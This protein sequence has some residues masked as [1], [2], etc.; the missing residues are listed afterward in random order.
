MSKRKGAW[1]FSAVT[2]AV[3]TFPGDMDATTPTNPS[4]LKNELQQME[5]EMKCLVLGKQRF[6]LHLRNIPLKNKLSD[7]E[8]ARTT[9]P[10]HLPVQGYIQSDRQ[11][12][13]DDDSLKLCFDAN[14]S[15]VQNQLRRA[16]GT[17][18]LAW[19]QD[20]PAYRD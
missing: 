13:I 6:L 5:I 9:T 19:A 12:A 8:L 2:A 4:R 11:R 3:W 10:R 18:Y 14:W 17:P 1:R 16:R 7:W 15:P 20:D